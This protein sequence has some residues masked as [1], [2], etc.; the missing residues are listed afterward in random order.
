MKRILQLKISLIEIEPEIWRRVLVPDS[1]TLRELH[2]VIQ[3]AMGWQDCH[4]HMFEIGG[5][6]FQT[7]FEDG[8]EL[9]V[10]D[11]REHRL[12]RLVRV[13]SR[14]LYT[15]DFGDDWNHSVK[16]EKA[17]PPDS[18]L[19]DPAGRYVPYCIGGARACPPEDCGG[20]YGYPELLQALA[21]PD[22][23]DYRELADWARGFEPEA[24]DI[25]ETNAEIEAFWNMYR[26]R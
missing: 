5:R 4:L 19:L 15:Y 23:P 12:D 22:N 21:E 25:G 2:G 6:H 16:V 11:E 24:F 20:P 7:P 10:E 14:F 13:K 9:D 8:L 3:G 18:G 1:L 17:M 26:K